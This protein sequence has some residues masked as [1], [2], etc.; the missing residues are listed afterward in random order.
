MKYIYL[1]I[2]K[3]IADKNRQKDKNKTKNHEER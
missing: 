3:V 2:F 1:A